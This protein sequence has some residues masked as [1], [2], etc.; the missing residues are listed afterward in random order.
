MG[1]LRESRD[2]A[3]P[4]SLIDELAVGTTLGSYTLTR[5]LGEG[6]MGVVYAAFDGKLERE[7]ALKLLRS[8]DEGHAHRLLIEARSLAKVHHPCVLTVHDA[9]EYD[10][11]TYIAME[12][13]R[14]GTLRDYLARTHAS[15]TTVLALYSRAASGLA[16]AHA[17]GLVHRDFKP[18]NVL[19]DLDDSG[20][21]SRVLVSDFGLAARIEPTTKH[22]MTAATSR[23]G[24]PA[25]MAPEQIEG[26]AVDVR[27]DV[28]ALAASV[29]E[30]LYGKPPFVGSSL[31]TILKAMADNP[32]APSSPRVP[33]RVKAVLERALSV[34]P[35]SRPATVAE[36]AAAFDPARTSRRSRT[37][38]AVT[39]MLIAILIATS[40]WSI[41][42]R[43]A[44][45]NAAPKHRTTKRTLV[46]DFVDTSDNSASAKREWMGVGLRELMRSQLSDAPHWRTVSLLESAT[47]EKGM[48]L[49]KSQ[50]DA[51]AAVRVARTSFSD[52]L[53]EGS[54]SIDTNQNISAVAR[55][56]AGDT[57]LQIAVA[58]ATGVDLRSI[59]ADL[60]VKLRGAVG[61]NPSATIYSGLWP[62][63]ETAANAYGSALAEFAHN[64]YS[65]AIGDLDRVL[66][67]EPEFAEAAW[68]SNT[69]RRLLGRP[70]TSMRA[71]DISQ[72]PRDDAEVAAIEIARCDMNY[73][74]VEDR[75]RIR[76]E[77]DIF[78]PEL[79]MELLSSLAH[80]S[81]LA[82][83]LLAFL[84]WLSPA[85][86]RSII[87]GRRVNMLAALENQTE[88]L[89]AGPSCIEKATAD[90]LHDVAAKCSYQTAMAAINLGHWNDAE[91]FAS[92]AIDEAKPLGDH[93]LASRSSGIV[94]DVLEKEGHFHA[95]AQ[96]IRDYVADA[97]S[98]GD[99]TDAHTAE[100]SL[101]TALIETGDLGEARRLFD[102]ELVPHMLSGEEAKN[103]NY[104]QLKAAEAALLAGAPVAAERYAGASLSYYRAEHIERQIAFARMVLAQI[105]M[106]RGLLDDARSLANDALRVR[107][108][109]G[110]QRVASQSRSLVASIDI[111]DGQATRAEAELHALLFDP[112]SELLGSDRAGVLAQH[113]LSLIQL[114]RTGDATSEVNQAVSLSADNDSTTLALLV[115]RAHAVVTAA[116]GDANARTAAR[117]E[118][119]MLRR[120]ADNGGYVIDSLAL[121]LAQCQIDQL[122]HNASSTRHRAEVIGRTATAL[123]LGLIVN[124]AHALETHPLAD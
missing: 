116:N 61:M 74:L 67:I 101:A 75:A 71:L 93:I 41:H 19:V 53:V 73:E 120:R 90:G 95:A 52:F 9:G 60:G 15:P 104:A 21:I 30:G 32:R 10:D 80:N 58:H 91:R 113:A 68:L 57:G 44:S 2:A 8:D 48:M 23:A 12:L 122:E 81:P 50:L 115:G 26:G 17:A 3:A 38:A 13:V 72:L 78:D 117:S 7:V 16:A 99:Q 54:F 35:A 108:R 46:R 63:S 25:Y 42:R 56:V 119:D 24:T 123:G 51:D 31:Q 37:F 11:V 66:A 65:L 114:G 92:H 103:G 82:T 47:L 89:V 4:P 5:K 100:I 85:G 88:I 118:L 84:E 39:A 40:L 34:D 109:N 27:T 43:N 49:P 96:K 18:D 77:S 33:S 62:L 102:D 98:R 110:W 69:L 36:L 76:S 86:Q 111:A 107:Q 55:L 59:A 1:W 87:A 6:G 64:D 124:Q 20:A 22:G 105:D 97:R 70:T 45:A 14:G 28:F 112:S 106:A 79:R 121:Q 83:D 29:W 94:W